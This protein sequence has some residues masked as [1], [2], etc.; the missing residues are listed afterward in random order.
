MRGGDDFITRLNADRSQGQ[1]QRSGSGRD[2]NRVSCSDSSGEA[3][4]KARNFLT[5]NKAGAVNDSLDGR[6]NLRLDGRIL[7]FQINERDLNGSALL[8]LVCSGRSANNRGLIGSVHHE[9]IIKF[10]LADVGFAARQWAQFEY[11]R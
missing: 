1:Q 2:S 3:L 5:Q 6:I 10:H 7:S 9:I 11:Q 4:F 8:L